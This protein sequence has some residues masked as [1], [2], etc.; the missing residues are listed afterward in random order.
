MTD[1]E[2]YFDAT[3]DRARRAHPNRSRGWLLGHVE[4][5]VWENFCKSPL[6]CWS[7]DSRSNRFTVRG[8]P[9]PGKTDLPIQSTSQTNSRTSI[10][11]IFK[12]E[13]L[14]DFTNRS[15]PDR[16]SQSR[17]PID[18]WVHDRYE[19]HNKLEERLTQEDDLYR[20]QFEKRVARGDDFYRPKHGDSSKSKHTE[21]TKRAENSK[22]EETYGR[23]SRSDREVSSRTVSS[24]IVSS[25]TQP[26]ERYISQKYAI[27]QKVSD[28][29]ISE[30][31]VDGISREEERFVEDAYPNKSRDWQKWATEKAVWKRLCK[32]ECQASGQLKANKL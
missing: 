25:R 29:R 11:P 17:D 27:K 15:A 22:P 5:R 10:E 1:V 12:T 24:L 32:F 30:S 19:D 13:P 18:Y 9:F 28:N 31:R 2:T 16:G 6:S 4:Q 26:S 7:I 3:L 14:Q 23:S 8:D 20:P 21:V